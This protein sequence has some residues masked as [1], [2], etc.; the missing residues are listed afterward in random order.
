[1]LHFF[2]DYIGGILKDKS[3]QSL[4]SK[5]TTETWTS[6]STPEEMNFLTF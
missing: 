4:A 1:M 6:M 5:W 3:V 2:K